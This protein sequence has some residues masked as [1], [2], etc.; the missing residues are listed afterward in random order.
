MSTEP[1]PLS[2]QIITVSLGPAPTVRPFWSRA[3]RPGVCVCVCT[4]CPEGVIEADSKGTPL[5][6]P[7]LGRWWLCLGTAPDPQAAPT[8]T[9]SLLCPSA[10]SGQAVASGQLSPACRNGCCWGLRHHLGDPVGTGRRGPTHTPW[11]APEDVCVWRRERQEGPGGELPLGASPGS[12]SCGKTR[13]SQSTASLLQVRLSV[14]GA[15]ATFPAW[16]GSCW[17]LP[18]DRPRPWRRK[19]LCWPLTTPQSARCPVQLGS[20]LG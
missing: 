12:W 3:H 9:G 4:P 1:I 20:H 8:C 18:C 13:G 19:D 7:M 10:H 16:P 15:P 5:D 2:N 17:G 6:P 14:A 11:A